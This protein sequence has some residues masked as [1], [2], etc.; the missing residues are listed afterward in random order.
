MAYNHLKLEVL[1]YLKI[2]NDAGKAFTVLVHEL[3]NNYAYVIKKLGKPIAQD[4]EHKIELL[5]PAKPIPYHI[6]QTM[7]ERELK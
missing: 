2:P 1:Q 7:S 3:V 6:Q 4:I 5:E